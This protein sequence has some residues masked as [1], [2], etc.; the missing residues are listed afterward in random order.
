MEI[1][2]RQNIRKIEISKVRACLEE[3]FSHLSLNTKQASFVF[4]DNSFIRELNQKYFK[5]DNPTDV[6]AFPLADKVDPDYLG[7]V[8]VSVEEAVL[9]AASL[10]LSWP[11]E[12]LLYLVHGIMHLVGLDDKTAKQREE[13]RKKEKEVLDRLKDLNLGL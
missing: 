5:K 1:L 4:C 8:I 10:D 12:V 6:I 11:K 9:T 3:I 7:E 2:N 13:M